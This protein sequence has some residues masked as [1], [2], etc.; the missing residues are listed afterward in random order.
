M[1]LNWSIEGIKDYKELLVK[2]VDKDGEFEH[3]NPVTDGLVWMTM[4]VDIGRITE[5]NW[6]EFYL[7]VKMYEALKGRYFYDYEV[8]PELIQRHIG[9]ATNVTTS[10]VTWNRKVRLWMKEQ[11]STTGEKWSWS[12]EKMKLK[13]S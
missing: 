4:I 1:S 12:C 5:E 9:L 7:R 10:K 6:K 3:T 2:G 13:P 11:V 8:T